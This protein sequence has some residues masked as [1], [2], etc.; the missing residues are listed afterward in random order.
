MG[1]IIEPGFTGRVGNLIFYNLNGKKYVRTVPD[2]VKQTKAT[3]AKAKVF[4]LASTIGSVIRRQMRPIITEPKNNAMQTR[5]VTFIYQWLLNVKDQKGSKAAEARHLV[6]FQFVEQTHSVLDRWKIGLKI[7]LPAPDEVQIKIPEFV[8]TEAI[9]APTDTAAVVCRIATSVSDVEEGF[10]IR[11]DS[12][13]LVFEYNDK[14]V[15][16][17]TIS[18]KLSTPKGGIVLTGISL[19]YRIARK[20]YQFANTNKNYMPSDIVDAKYL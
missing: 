9:K 5:L 20:G 19:E 13:K 17:Q 2:R 1:K 7:I 15:A 3:K 12:V 10:G 14:P 8:P 18:F 11:N 4:G 16:A 6:G